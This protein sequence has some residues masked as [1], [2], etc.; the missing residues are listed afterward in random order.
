MPVYN[1]ASVSS[2]CFPYF[3]PFGYLTLYVIKRI[4]AH[5]NDDPNTEI[6]VLQHADI[7]DEHT[8]A[9]T[10]HLRACF[11]RAE[12][13]VKTFAKNTPQ[14]SLCSLLTPR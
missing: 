3:S 13:R 12:V 6:S 4:S 5:E 2:I 7:Y 11:P 10:A 1:N 14:T 8:K 9:T